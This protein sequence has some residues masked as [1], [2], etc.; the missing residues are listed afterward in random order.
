MQVKKTKKPGG[1][2]QSIRQL[3]RKRIEKGTQPARLGKLQRKANGGTSTVLR[4]FTLKP[5][6]KE[7]PALKVAMLQGKEHDLG[8]EEKQLQAINDLHPVI[9]NLKGYKENKRWSETT[10]PS[11]VLHDMLTQLDKFYEQDI[12]DND[13][14]KVEQE[15]DGKY[16]IEVLNTY[17]DNAA[18]FIPVDFLSQINRS[19]SRVHNFIVYAII[20]VKNI[21]QISLFYDWCEFSKQGQGMIYEYL[22][23]RFYDMTAEDGGME[24]MEACLTYYGH[25]GIPAAYCKLF[26]SGASLR[27]FNK[28]LASF[29]PTNNIE[30]IALPFLKL[31]S[32]LAGTKIPLRKYCEEPW[33][34]GELTP[35]GYYVVVWTVDKEDLMEE[36]FCEVMDDQAQNLGAVP[37]TW[38]CK[39]DDSNKL[40]E[41]I[42]FCT[43]VEEFFETGREMA[44][45]IKKLVKDKPQ[46]YPL[47]LKPKKNYNG[48]RLIDILV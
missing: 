10:A 7:L 17:G 30:R 38:K 47:P 45:A 18:I 2:P 36:M 43:L 20:L 1:V 13:D 9:S 19:H 48:K 8:S 32:K 25:K 27:E 37:F 40:T 15:D 21:N 26:N 24:E 11:E 41:A 42:E 39:L 4:P 28:Q 34:N 29:V 22:H 14:W 31:A 16:Y 12:I 23:D 46:E 3:G 44:H 6:T 33:Q 5:F 35:E